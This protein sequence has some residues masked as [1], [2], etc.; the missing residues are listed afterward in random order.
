MCHQH[1]DLGVKMPP[2]FFKLS[3]VSFAQVHDYHQIPAPPPAWPGLE[4][5]VSREGGRTLGDIPHGGS[6]LGFPLHS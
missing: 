5:H 1:T 2:L 3:S 4:A 6:F